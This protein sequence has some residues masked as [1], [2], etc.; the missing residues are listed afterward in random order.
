[1][2]GGG[3]LYYPAKAIP[4]TD[5]RNDYPEALAQ[6]AS[7]YQRGRN[8]F[9]AAKT[10]AQTHGWPLNWRLIELPGVGHNARKMLAAPQAAEALSP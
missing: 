2:D 1:M 8:V 3:F 4:A 9:E 10:V 5:E 7:R 6:G